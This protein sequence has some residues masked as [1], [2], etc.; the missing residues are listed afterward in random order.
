MGA[1]GPAVFS[2]DT[3]CDVRDDWRELIG[4]GL[5][6]VEATEQMFAQWRESLDDP[7]DGPVF[8]LALAAAQ[9][10]AGRL[11][12]RVKEQALSI[13]E[14]GSS[15]ERWQEDAK[16]LNK[17]IAVLEKLR[18]QLLSEPPTAK[19][20]RKVVKAA[21]EWAQGEVIAYRLRSGK[22][23]LFRVVGLTMDKGGTYPECQFYEWVGDSVPS[24]AQIKKL[25]AKPGVVMMCGVTQ[26]G[27]PADRL[28][29]TGVTIPV[30]T[31]MFGMG[32]WPWSIIDKRLAEAWGY[33]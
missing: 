10:K 27:Y 8:W 9:W 12:Q 17:R 28:M 31:P 33:E 2:D 30:E 11:E 20:I 25:P 15:L 18:E 32:V 19:K 7:D 14:D 21:C 13:I 5:P 6:V 26:R 1:W 16:L 4:D 22:L 24:K 23:V 29:R 3:A